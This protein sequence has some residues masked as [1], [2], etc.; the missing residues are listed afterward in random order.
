MS[1]CP[2]RKHMRQQLQRRSGKSRKFVRRPPEISEQEGYRIMQLV[3]SGTVFVLLVAVKLLFPEQMNL[4]GAP[5]EQILDKNMDVNEVFSAVGNALFDKDWE[6]DV[7]QAVFGPQDGG[8]DISDMDE[9]E[10]I[11]FLDDGNSETPSSVHFPILYTDTNLPD[12]VNLQQMVLGFDYCTPVLGEVSS[13]FGYRKDPLVGK[14][15]FHYGL[16]ITADE[17]AEIVSFADGVV[18]VTADSS[19]YGKYLIVAHDNGCTTLYAHCKTIH[20][21]SGQNVKMG[22]RI[23]QV[24][25]SG[26]AT[27]PHLHFEL[28]QNG[29]YLNPVYYV[30]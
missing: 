17:G 20:A 19:S 27:G 26:Q 2:E 6:K 21:H 1:E 23:A 4:V 18:T 9:K 15:R 24:G 8:E 14:E 16:D 13:Y 30:F 25:D 29:V 7:Y 11:V 5:L 3:V 28:Q 22:E 10:D 12:H